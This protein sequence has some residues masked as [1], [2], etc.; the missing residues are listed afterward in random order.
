MFLSTEVSDQYRTAR[1]HPFPAKASTLSS[2]SQSALLQ[3]SMGQGELAPDSSFV[4]KCKPIRLAAKSPM[5]A[6]SNSPVR[7][8]PA[9][10]QSGGRHFESVAQSQR[11]AYVENRKPSSL[12]MS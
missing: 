7:L 8:Q 10:I 6:S 5:L 2:R 3:T 1:K 9:R 12:T 11:S 4:G